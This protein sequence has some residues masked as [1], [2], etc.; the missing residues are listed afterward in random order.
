M[1][2]CRAAD[3]IRSAAAVAGEAAA[4]TQG[5][6]QDRAASALKH[7]VLIA[8]GAM[9]ALALAWMVLTS[10]KSASSQA[11]TFPVVWCRTRSVE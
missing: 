3:N 5:A 7:I 8:V 6:S 1:K 10:F 4:T 2:S 11:L 9:F